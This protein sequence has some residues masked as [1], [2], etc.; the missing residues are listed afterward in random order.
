M[1]AAAVAENKAVVRDDFD[2]VISS[3]TK[4]GDICT[5]TDI[6]GKSY[7]SHLD[8]QLRVTWLTPAPGGEEVDNLKLANELVTRLYDLAYGEDW[9]QFQYT[10]EDRETILDRT[11][12]SIEELLRRVSVERTT[13]RAQLAASQAQVRVLREV[14]KPFADAYKEV[15]KGLRSTLRIMHPSKD[16]TVKHLSATTDHLKAAANAFDLSVNKEQAAD[17][18]GLATVIPESAQKRA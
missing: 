9:T 11:Y 16:N 17:A 18:N 7:P 3:I 10:N 5:I 13:L 12:N 2:I 14:L 4:V 15:P 8:R 1:V 6:E